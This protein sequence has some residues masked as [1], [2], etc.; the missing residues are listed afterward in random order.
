M[1]FILIVVRP[2]DQYAFHHFSWVSKHAMK[3]IRERLILTSMYSCAQQ[4]SLALAI[5]C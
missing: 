5:F 2:L 1:H 4:S 3:T